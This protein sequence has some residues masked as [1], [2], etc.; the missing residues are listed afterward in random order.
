MAFPYLS[1]NPGSGSVQEAEQILNQRTLLGEVLPSYGGP[2]EGHHHR[3]Q[4]KAVDVRSMHFIGGGVLQKGMLPF[5]FHLDC[6]LPDALNNVVANLCQNDQ[7]TFM[8]NCN[9]A[10]MKDKE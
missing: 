5:F 1:L 2:T 8:Y 9:G 10:S 3:H 6:F 4:L 7:T